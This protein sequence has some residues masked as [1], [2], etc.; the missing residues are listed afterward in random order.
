MA[1]QAEGVGIRA[2]SPKSAP[3]PPV[4]VTGDVVQV[5]GSLPSS[6]MIFPMVASSDRAEPLLQ[7]LLPG[8]RRKVE[9]VP[10]AEREGEAEYILD[11]DLED[12]LLRGMQDEGLVL[13]AQK[14]T[15]TSTKDRGG[16]S[17]PHLLSTLT[18]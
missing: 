15:E 12:V 9:Y 16:R 11:Q 7:V 1:R 8:A 5:L 2:L 10:C 4:H 14:W 17:L 13:L 6:Y 18:T 3:A